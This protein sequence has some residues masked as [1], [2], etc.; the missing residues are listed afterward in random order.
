MM[1][2]ALRNSFVPAI[3][4]LTFC[5]ALFVCFAAVIED[6]G[7]DTITVDDDGG[8]DFTTIQDAI[9]ASEDGDII[10]VNPGTYTENVRVNKSVTIRA[11]SGDPADT[12]V[13]ASEID[14]HVFNIVVDHVSMSGFTIRDATEWS[15]GVKLDGVE[16]CNVSGNVITNCYDGIAVWVSSNITLGN[17]LI[18]ETVGWTAVNIQMDCN[19]NDIHNNTIYSNPGNGIYMGS[20]CLHNRVTWNTIYDNKEEDEAIGIFLDHTTNFTSVTF[21]TVHSN[22]VGIELNDACDYNDISHNEVYDNIDIGIALIILFQGEA[23]NSNNSIMNNTVYGNPVGINI[24][25]ESKDNTVNYNNI[26]DNTGYGVDAADNNGYTVD[27]T[28]NWWG[29]ASGPYHPAK[30]AAGTGDNITDYVEFDPWLTAPVGEEE[31]EERT[32]FYV[33]DDAPDGGNGSEERPYNKIQDAIDAAGAGATIYVSG[34]KYYENVIINITLSLIGN[35]SEYTTIDGGGSGPAA[36]IHGDHVNFTGFTCTGS[37]PAGAG[38]E[39]TS[40]FNHIHNNTATGNHYGI[41]LY[42]SN[43]NTLMN[44]NASR[45]RDGIHL[46]HSNNNTLMW[47]DVNKNSGGS[48]IY[49]GHSNNNVLVNINASN[50]WDGFYPNNRNSIYL[51]SSNNNAVTGSSASMNDCGIY[52]DRA[53]GNTLSNNTCRDNTDGICLVSSSNY[54]V[55]SNNIASNN[56]DGIFLRDSSHNT[57]TGNTAWD[58]YF[59]GIYLEDSGYSTL[60]GNTMSANKYNF[61]VRSNSLPGFMQDMDATNLVN[62]KKSYYLIDE[63]DMQV[64]GDAGF[65][66]IVNSTGITVSNLSLTGNWQGLLL[67]YT[68]NST[69]ENITVTDNDY[70]IY[71]YSSDHNTIV[72]NDVSDNIC[73]SQFAGGISLYYSNHNTIMGNIASGNTEGIYLDHSCDNTIASNIVSDNFHGISLFYSSNNNA[74][75]S[76]NASGNSAGIRLYYSSNDNNITGNSIYANSA[77]G[78]IL[79]SSGHNSIANNSVSGNYWGIRMLSSSDGNTLTTNTISVNR[80]GIGLEDSSGNNSAHSNTIVDNEQYGIDASFNNGYTIDATYNW[81]GDASGPYHSTGNPGGKGDNV[82]D[83]V[84]FDPWLTA[85]VGEEEPEKRTEFYVDDDAPDGGNGSEERP[86]NRIQDAI[87]AAGAGAT[88]YVSGGTYHE[89]LDVDRTLTIRAISGSL[90][91]A[92]VN[93]SDGDDHVFHVTADDVNI[94]GFTVMNATHW[95]TGGIFL[96]NAAGCNISGNDVSYNYYGIYMEGS[97]DSTITGN[98]LHSNLDSGICLSGG[99][100]NVISDNLV[101]AND[102]DGILLVSGAEGNRIS[103]NTLESNGDSGIKMYESHE[104][105]ISGNIVDSN[106]IYDVGRE[107]CN[108]IALSGS[109]GNIFTDNHASGNKYFEF[110]S[111]GDSRENEVT[112]LHLGS[113][114]TAISFTYDHGIGV[115]SVTSAPPDP[116]NKSSIGK[117][118]N[119]TNVT[120]ESWIELKVHYANEDPGP[121]DRSSLRIFRYTGTEWEIVPDPNGVNLDENFVYANITSFSIFAPMGDTV[122][123]ARPNLTV[124]SPANNSEISGTVTISGSASDEDGNETIQKVE[125]SIDGGVWI[126]VTGTDS[127]NHQWDSTTVANGNYEIR[128]RAYDGED[129]SDMVTWKLSVNNEETPSDDD[130]DDDDDSPGFGAALL[131]VS[132]A[133]VGCTPFL[134]R[135]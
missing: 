84:D 131:L 135:R 44:N 113:Y 119:V 134:R 118:V 45:N 120:G 104:N 122:V 66:G 103:G 107:N 79:H 20:S 33:D 70:G 18:Y 115:R 46:D 101:T 62:G 116:T 128:V 35:D 49:L 32:E 126:T 8:T 94:S 130:D 24:S 28:G 48:G 53:S 78:I 52:L 13:E 117:Y 36:T 85:P 16:H 9:N 38:I 30:N 100:G 11:A 43:N 47:I 96:D 121:I 123:N 127:W 22:K 1:I 31:P 65:V 40:A 125:I 68:S 55:I 42:Y 37:S 106:G 21:N 133:F 72:N 129:Y 71:V 12:I 15:A 29:D 50:N 102:F 27:A 90:E 95:F 14:K 23:G 74:I 82:T 63:K 64:P 75:T 109:N 58:N 19:N 25:G 2:T 76:N 26:H 73:F 88:I 59:K 69:I 93:A 114:P 92:V 87:N 39:V 56:G 124:T 132:A 111:S 83:H 51:F 81:W 99:S 108:G 10:E 60:A 6:A 3:G 34:G 97:H 86:Y 61:G 77:N 80:I 41:R 110:Y 98:T 105:T 4:T 57:L 112:D 5:A 17:N 89:N 91:D 67:A 7:G 54:N